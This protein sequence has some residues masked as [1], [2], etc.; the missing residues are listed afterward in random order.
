MDAVPVPE[1][2]TAHVVHGPVETVAA[3]QFQPPSLPVAMA[4]RVRVDAE[5]VD[6]AVASDAGDPAET[7]RAIDP[8]DATDSRSRHLPR[9]SERGSEANDL[10]TTVA[11]STSL[12]Q[13][14]LQMAPPP[15]TPLPAPLQTAAAATESGQLELGHQEGD[16]PLPTVTPAGVPGRFDLV[17]PDRDLR[18][19]GSGRS[20]KPETTRA[21]SADGANAGERTNGAGQSSG[22]NRRFEV[23]SARTAPTEDTVAAAGVLMTPIAPKSPSPGPVDP[24]RPTVQES[25]QAAGSAATLTPEG[26]VSAAQAMASV[27]AATPV[28]MAGA[29]PVPAPAQTWIQTPVTQPGFSDEVVVELV[30]RA[31]QAEQGRQEVTLHL[32]PAELGPV[33]VSIE[34]K[35]STARIEFGAS[36]AL[37]RHHLEAALPGLAEALQDEGLSLTHSRVHEVSKEALAASAAGS[38]DPTGSGGAGSD[39][40]ARSEAFADGRSGFGERAPR[41]STEVFTV[42][43]RSVATSPA[44]A[45][46]RPKPGRAGRLDLFA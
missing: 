43:G 10:P 35:G 36:E 32:N 20:G 41:R 17:V 1:A 22:P 37:T 5:S 31:G 34:L 33:A 42:D 14:M 16:A 46:L 19:N 15:A 29:S 21:M 45:S 27:T 26:L 2:A 6:L 3:P 24:V 18:G 11:T 8:K 44:P 13:W 12:M 30:R 4:D 23:P 38:G 28:A 7:S 40:R 25:A 9:R 39:A